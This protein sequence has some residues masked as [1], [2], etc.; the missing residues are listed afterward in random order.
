MLNGESILI[1]GGTGSFGKAFVR[2]VLDRYQ[3]DRVVVFRRDE[4]KQSEMAEHPDFQGHSELRFFSGE[5]R[6]RDFLQ[7]ALEGVDVVVHAAARKQ[8]PTC[9][10]NPVETIKTNVHGAQNV[11][12]AAIDRGVDCVIALSTDKACNPVNLHGVSKLCSDKLFIAGNACVG[13]K[14]TAFSL[15]RYSNVVGSGS[16]V[17]L[18]MRQRESGRLSITHREK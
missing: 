2:R 4:S 5:V 17:P 8:V 6:D 13:V 12:D 1:T 7:R 10:Y 3:P 11:I 16:L 14:N 15:V 18:F 9:E